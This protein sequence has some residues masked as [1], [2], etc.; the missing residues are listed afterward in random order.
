M[1]HINKPYEFAADEL[2]TIK[3]LNENGF[4]Y[5]EWGNETLQSIRS[6]IRKH[7]RE[8]QQ[9]LCCYCMKPVSLQAAGNAHIEHI[10]PKSIFH[11]FIFEPKNLCVICAEC[12]TAKNNS[13]VINDDEID[14]CIGPAKLY[15]RSTERFKIVHPHIDEYSEHIIRTGIFYIDRSPKGHFTIGVCKLNIAA[16]KF[17]HSEGALDDYEFF[18]MM[19]T[20]Q[21][22]DEQEKRT[23]F[24]K[25]RS[26]IPRRTIF[27][28][29]MSNQ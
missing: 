9:G 6:S 28:A 2:E 15:P 22:G 5:R 12:N 23:V 14:T 26:L 20:F 24:E 10:L 3:F 13:N 27:S 7:Y 17:G 21:S 16:H 1:A 25:I 18:L 11:D 4:T 8:V 29:E 19:Q